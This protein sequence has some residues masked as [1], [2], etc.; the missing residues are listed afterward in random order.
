MLP[1]NVSTQISQIGLIRV[2]LILWSNPLAFLF[3]PP[4]CRSESNP[5]S[6]GERWTVSDLRFTQEATL[7]PPG[8]AGA[9]GLFLDIRPRASR[10]SGDGARPFWGVR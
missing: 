5:R 6:M 8:I 4:R 10:R 9:A 3:E 7:P 2:P 1:D